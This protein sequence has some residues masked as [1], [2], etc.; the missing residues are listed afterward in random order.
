MSLKFRTFG[1]TDV[2]LVRSG[3]EDYL[4]IDE[5]NGVVGVCDGMGGH[6]AGEVASMSASQT[7]QGI[8]DHFQ[9]EIRDD[10]RLGFQQNVPISGDILLRAVRL[11][12]REIYNRAAL[13]PALSGMGTTIVALSLEKDIVSVAHV[14]D[15]R[16]YKIVDGRVEALTEDHSWI[17][18]IQRSQT[19]TSDEAASMVGKNVITRALGVRDTVEV[20][21]R[22]FKIKPGDRFMLCS[23]GLCGFADDD[24]ISEVV[25]K[26]G[27]DN[28][29]VVDNLVQMANDRGG[30]DNVTIAVVEVDEVEESAYWDVE[31]F[32]LPAETS[33]ELQAEDD[34]L[35]KIRT[36][37]PEKE[38]EA[39]EDKDSG[40]RSS[41]IW[42]FVI[43][44]IVAIVVIYYSTK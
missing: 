1:K 31:V 15:S 12:N 13:D 19:V 43:F 37:S 29:Q 22:A 16:A 33:V 35:E 39:A 28:Q 36:H 14:G 44:V 20:D 11:A 24:E 27:D 10:P 38:D 3:N 42:I 40:G 21:F 41:L 2:G 17:A 23:D 5:K 4:H 8:F 18:E 30:A 6:Q 9:K 25:Y 26:C 32:T 34:W 7:L